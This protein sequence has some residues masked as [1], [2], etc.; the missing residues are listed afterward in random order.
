M[1]A[2][3][4]FV[5]SSKFQH[6]AL[7]LGVLQRMIIGFKFYRIKYVCSKLKAIFKVVKK[8]T[9]SKFGAW[10]SLPY[11]YFAVRNVSRKSGADGC[12]TPLASHSEV[13]ETG[14]PHFVV[15]VRIFRRRTPNTDIMLFDVFF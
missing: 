3:G 15:N 5:K 7:L 2:V 11:R 13:I 9:G 4:N 1:K 12:G 8:N 6:L 14:T 10:V